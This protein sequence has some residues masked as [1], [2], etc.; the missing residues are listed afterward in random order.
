M[1]GFPPQLWYVFD[2]HMFV[3]QLLKCTRSKVFDL[4]IEDFVKASCFV[5]HRL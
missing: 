1:I 3:E 2:A 4:F 5:F